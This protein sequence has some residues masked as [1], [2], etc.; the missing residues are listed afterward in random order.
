VR[1]IDV[2]SKID[3]LW[4]L[5]GEAP[6]LSRPN[7]IVG[8]LSGS[9]LVGI[10][11]DSDLRKYI[12]KYKK[13]PSSISEI[14]RL[15]FIVIH[16]NESKL[17]MAKELSEKLTE[18]GWS[19]SQPIKDV[20]VMGK[21]NF[22]K[23]YNFSDFSDE[24]E[25]IRDE[26]I[27]WGL[28]YVGL[29]L[30]AVLNYLKFNVTG[31]ESDNSRLKRLQNKDFYILEPR[32]EDMLANSRANQFCSSLAEINTKLDFNHGERSNRRIHIIAVNT[33]FIKNS[34]LQIDDLNSVIASISSDLVFGD[35]VILRSTV[36][37][38]M[39]EII[40]K[41]L[42]EL[43]GLVCGVDFSVGF[44]PERTVEG[45]AIFEIQ[46]LPQ[47]VS[48]QTSTCLLKIRNIVEKWAPTVISASSPKAAEMAKLAN[49]SFRDYFFAF[50]N[51]LTLIAINSGVNVSEVI[52]IAN[53]GYS[54]SNIPTPSPGVGGPCLTKDPYILFE[55]Q[56]S[57]K[58]VDFK[59]LR[60]NS[61]ILKSR[62]I[63]ESMPNLIV[64]KFCNDLEVL[65]ILTK[66]LF[67]VGVAFKGVPATNDI[68]NSPAVEMLEEFKKKGF[69]IEAWDATADCQAINLENYE[70]DAK[71]VS[72]NRDCIILIGN[73]FP[74]NL[75]R[76]MN[77]IKHFNVKV[78]LDPYRMLEQNNLTYFYNSLGITVAD[79]TKVWI[80]DPQ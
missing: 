34:G 65:N 25:T 62:R 15:D 47:I 60:E 44:A 11:T 64:G 8:V 21:D 50:A 78:I 48:G 33:P 22:F 29:T 39:T 28:G 36:P 55:S 74:G 49:N 41:K 61:A 38:G 27:V 71:V 70:E 76:V 9:E 67:L 35:V 59:L 42:E 43:T 72:T 26:Y 68:R 52:E 14:V 54:R 53:K 37:I 69:V 73:N 13:L 56:N 7:S 19:T 46:S 18:K 24:L 5:L 16:Q 58:V 80:K 31:V 77:L 57:G 6:S 75:D 4:D 30:M 3:K 63:N 1:T 66:K 40:S 2:S 12:A 20:I 45:N 32:L 51:E 79:M 10:I 23:K 17:I